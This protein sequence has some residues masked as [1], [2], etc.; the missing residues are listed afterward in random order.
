MGFT[1]DGLN[2]STDPKLVHLSPL[3]GTGISGVGV[4]SIDIGKNTN[5]E[6]R[7]LGLD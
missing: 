6:G 1:S 2:L 4:K 7:Y 3:E 5:G